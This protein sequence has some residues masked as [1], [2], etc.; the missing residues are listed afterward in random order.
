MIPIPISNAIIIPFAD[1]KNNER[2]VSLSLEFLL[3]ALRKD[4]KE[5]R[6]GEKMDMAD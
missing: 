5:R 2:V 1:L 3:P 4:D 6:D